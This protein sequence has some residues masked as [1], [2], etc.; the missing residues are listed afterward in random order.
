MSFWFKIFGQALKCVAL[1]YSIVFDFEA[2]TFDSKPFLRAIPDSVR[3]S[4][5]DE[6]ARSFGAYNLNWHDD[7]VIYSMTDCW[8]LEHA[9]ENGVE[10]FWISKKTKEVL[11]EGEWRVERRC[12][13]AVCGGR[14]GWVFFFVFWICIDKP[15][16]IGN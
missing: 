7:L 1:G 10:K 15:K 12:K 9:D 6:L 8:T 13:G 4:C 16:K 3:K 14:G 5:S 2:K 11:K